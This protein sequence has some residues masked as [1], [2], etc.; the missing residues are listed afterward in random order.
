[1]IDDQE[2]ED[3]EQMEFLRKWHAAQDARKPGAWRSFWDTVAHVL[4]GSA[5][6]ALMVA[7]VYLASIGW[8]V[9]AC[10]FMIGGVINLA[11][12]LAN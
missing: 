5:S 6:I 11:Y 4:I 3:R 12:F 10:T 8:M 1:M 9:P 2:I 7:A